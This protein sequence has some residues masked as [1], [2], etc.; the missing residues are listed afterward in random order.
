MLSKLQALSE[1]KR[2]IFLEFVLQDIGS[3]CSIISGEEYEEFK[4]ILTQILES[5]NT[6]AIRLLSFL[7][8]EQDFESYYDKCL[9]MIEDIIGDINEE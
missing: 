6:I 4:N 8:G 7:L 3:E 9:P 5:K 2:E 1:E